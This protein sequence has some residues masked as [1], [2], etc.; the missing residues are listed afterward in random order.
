M[1]ALPL[2]LA[3]ATAPAPPESSTTP[4]DGFTF[5]LGGGLM[6][7]S[8][9]GGTSGHMSSVAGVNGGGDFWI[10]AMATSWLSIGIGTGGGSFSHDDHSWSGGGFYLRAE[11][12]PLFSLG[13]LWND[14]SVHVYTG[15][16]GGT[17]K[18]GDVE[19]AKS[20][21]G[22]IGGGLGWEPIHF[23]HDHFRGGP[24]TSV[25]YVSWD[26][27]GESAHAVRFIVGWRLAYYS[28]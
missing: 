10:G 20:G 6:L 8:A 12:F 22:M 26:R 9:T 4:R 1:I 13:G 21:G 25:G 28:D 15:L 16:G 23:L 14:V 3:L 11:I 5:G 2:L 27:D 17:L 19:V 18:R 7:G 24:M